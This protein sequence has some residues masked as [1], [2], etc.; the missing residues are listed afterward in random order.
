MTD[1]FRGDITIYREW[2]E[3]VRLLWRTK[4]LLAVATNTK[5][6]PLDILPTYWNS[7]GIAPPPSACEQEQ[8]FGQRRKEQSYWDEKNEQSLGILQLKFDKDLRKQA[9]PMQSTICHEV[10]DHLEA[11]YGGAHD[12]VALAAFVKKAKIG[13]KSSDIM[14]VFLS[15]FI[16]NHREGGSDIANGDRML[17]DLILVLEDNPRTEESMRHA[18]ISKLN[19]AQ[20]QKHL[21][22]EDRHYK[23]PK[24]PETKFIMQVQTKNICHNLRDYGSCQF[25][26]NCRYSHDSSAFKDTS[27]DN[28]KKRGRSTSPYYKRETEREDR[29]S[30]SRSPIRG[31][32][33]SPSRRLQP[34]TPLAK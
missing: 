4:G 19:F 20:T 16:H 2:M 17:A 33:R 29:R 18:R 34:G 14:T 1:I 3:E 31:S 26:S 27:A 13:L 5:E 6:R 25:G 22:E 24:E 11:L 28:N 8:C 15:Q 21:I 7:L 10:Y 23:A 9:G 12:N 32:S 30:Q